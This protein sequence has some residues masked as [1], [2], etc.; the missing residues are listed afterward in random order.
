MMF[1]IETARRLFLWAC[2][3]VTAG[4]GFND[5]FFRMAAVG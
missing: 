2:L 1:R 3:R 5:G 4:K